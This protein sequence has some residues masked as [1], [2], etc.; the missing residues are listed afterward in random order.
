MNAVKH[1]CIEDS[2]EE[3]VVILKDL[4]KE[5]DKTKELLKVNGHAVEREKLGK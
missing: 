1:M 3:L 4:K 5:T 2:V